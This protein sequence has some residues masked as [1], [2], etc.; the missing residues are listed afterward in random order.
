MAPRPPQEPPRPLQDAPRTPQDPSK[1]PQDPLQ[2]ALRT[3]Q[4]IDFGRFWATTG[5][6]LAPN[7]QPMNQPFN[8]TAKHRRHGGGLA[9]GCWIYIYIYIYIH[10]KPPYI[11][12]L[13]VYCIYDNFDFAP[14]N[15]NSPCQTAIWALG[16]AWALGPGL[17]PG[18][19][20]GPWC[21]VWALFPGLTGPGPWPGSFCKDWALY[22][23]YIEATNEN[24]GTARPLKG[25]HIVYT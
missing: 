8:Q 19:R 10:T 13:Y 11:H 4:H 2:E 14:W 6:M 21:L 9:E 3:P 23:F 7:S 24:H 20:L 16:P 22:N 15:K 18:P 12:I 5:W 17:G 1:S 25:L